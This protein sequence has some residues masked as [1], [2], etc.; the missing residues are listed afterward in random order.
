MID[1]YRLDEGIYVPPIPVTHREAEFSSEGFQ[2]L[3]SMQANH[4]WYKGRH[5]FLLCAVHRHVPKVRAGFRPCRVLDLGGGCGGWLAHLLRHKKFAVSEAALADSSAL[6]LRMARDYL[7]EGVKRYQADVLNLGW[8]DRWDVAFLLDVLE[9][10]PQDEEALRGLH[11]ALAEGGLLF[12]TTPALNCFWTWNDEFSEHQRR[13]SR[14]DFRRLASRCGY[15]LVEARYFMFWLSPLLL[16]SRLAVRSKAGQ[17]TAEQLSRLVDE[18]HR[19]PGPVVN[20]ILTAIFACET[21]WG[22]HVPFPWGTSILAVLQKPPRRQEPVPQR[23][24][25][26]DRRP[27]R[28]PVAGGF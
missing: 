16:L 11:R 3:R 8:E 10:I 9:H 17:M 4:F 1:P 27:T 26:P 2:Q 15:R 24:A 5:R 28:H 18:M 14:D 20:S 25:R 13:Y 6:A 19:V 21:P 12:V 22:H 7:P 23:A